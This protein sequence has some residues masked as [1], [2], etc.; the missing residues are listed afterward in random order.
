MDSVASQAETGMERAA[1]VGSAGG[2]F[3]VALRGVEFFEDVPWDIGRSRLAVAS[4]R[5]LQAV[6]ATCR[7]EGSPEFGKQGLK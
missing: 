2:V 5:E 6:I 3:C 1:P 7:G 4:V